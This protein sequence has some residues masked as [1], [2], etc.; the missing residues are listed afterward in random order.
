MLILYIKK[1]YKNLRLSVIMASVFLFLFIGL[2]PTTT[3][4]QTT[5]LENYAY[6]ESSTNGGTSVSILTSNEPNP[7]WTIKKNVTQILNQDNISKSRDIESTSNNEISNHNL[8]KETS[9]LSNTTITV[10]ITNSKNASTQG[11]SNVNSDFNGDG[12]SDL[13]IGVSTED[14]GNLQDAGAVNV[15]YGT[16]GGLNGIPLSP[17][18][19]KVDQ[20]WT[21]AITGGVEAGDNFGSSLAIADFN[22]DGFSDLAIGVP[23]EDIDT[24]R[25][26][27]AVNVIY[28]S[29]GG[30]SSTVKPSQV[31]TQNSPEIEGGAE[32]TDRF[33][34][35]L[36]S[37]DFNGDGFSD[38]AIGVPTESVGTIEAAGAVNVMY[39]SSVGLSG[40][41]LSQGDGRDDQIWTQDSGNVWN[42][43]E[44]LDL[45]GSS[46]ATGDFNNDGFSDLA[47]G[48]LF[49]DLN[50][51]RDAGQVN[52]IY[53][54][55][56]GLGLGGAAQ[57]QIW[58][59]DSPDVNPNGAGDGIEDEPEIEDMFGSSLAT[60]D[61]NKDG[62]SDLAIGVK[63]ESV[64]IITGGGAV[65]VI[66]GSS[67]GLIGL[68]VGQGHGGKADQI[69]IQN[70]PN[71]EDD[72]EIGD[73]F[74]SS[75]ATGDFNK[76]MR[77]DLAIG[78]S[79]E[80]VDTIGNAGAVNVIYGSSLGLSSINLSPGN[81]RTDQIWTQDTVEFGGGD[82]E[83]DSET[84]DVFGSSLATGD[85]NKDGIT[86]LAVGVPGEDVDTIGNAGAVNVIYGSL[87]IAIDSGGLSA[88]VPLGG[89]GQ[90]D[91]IWTQ[92]S[93]NI[94]DDSE[95]G[96][97]F[98][99][100]LS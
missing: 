22:N 5:M 51:I 71:I 42:D 73:G 100:S 66:Y 61:F 24:L 97:R 26:T 88:T 64:D 72:S 54:A 57:N 70:S 82:I 18:N 40:V 23:N 34:S 36:A 50:T 44:F 84:I 91:Q 49:E 10:N 27:G 59:Q 69:W 47:I 43:P 77:S 53:G 95:T 52:L 46:L 45:F 15:I 28:G 8:K 29:S 94:E 39:G 33:G 41:V 68:E 79:S 21:Q 11:V 81:G 20:I 99:I 83:D 12:F 87:G 85:F 65:N 30:L 80:D 17:D 62:F 78:V 13:A 90:A 48:V 1:R 4:I 56:E 93:S 37:G 35:S 25:D 76:D 31:W 55:P 19:G 14:V 67:F 98:G 16:S 3:I 38:L 86:D 9:V 96:D 7:D 60:G 75:L 89:F 63:G 58:T 92:N 74:G 32:L 2:L 6:A